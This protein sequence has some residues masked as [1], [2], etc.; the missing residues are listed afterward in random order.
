MRRSYRYNWDLYT[1]KGDIYIA[2]GPVLWQTRTF[3]ASVSIYA[4]PGNCAVTQWECQD[5]SCIA[6]TKLCDLFPDCPDQSDEL[7]STCGK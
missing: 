1:W 2:A 6:A 5:G 3:M 4:D 7:Q